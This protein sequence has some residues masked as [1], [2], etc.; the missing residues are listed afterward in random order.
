M[1]S[2]LVSLPKWQSDCLL[3]VAFGWLVDELQGVPR[4]TNEHMRSLLSGEWGFDDFLKRGG[5]LC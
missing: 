2:L 3:P 5:L 4:V 1:A